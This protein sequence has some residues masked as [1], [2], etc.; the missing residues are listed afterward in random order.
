MPVV[1]AKSDGPRI[2]V[3]QRE[4]RAEQLAF[5]M[6]TVNPLRSAIRLGSS[7]FS[8]GHLK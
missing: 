6:P 3:K 5:D 1:S 7:F 2:H 8:E 4:P